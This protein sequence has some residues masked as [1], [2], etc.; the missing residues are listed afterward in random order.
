MGNSALLTIVQNGNEFIKV[1]WRY[2]RQFFDAKDIYIFDYQS[3]DNSLSGVNC[4]I[5]SV[6][7]AAIEDVPVGNKLIN[8]LKTKLLDTY[9][10]VMYADYD[11]IVYHPKGLDYVLTL[12]WDYYTTQGYEVVHKVEKEL[13]INWNEPLLKQRNYWYRCPMYDKSLITAIDVKWA[14]GNHSII[15]EREIVKGNTS[16]TENFIL[17]PKYLDNLLLIHLHKI[18]FEHCV[19]LKEQNLGRKDKA[20]IGG[21]HNQL[22]RDDVK[23]WFQTFDCKLTPM[24]GVLKL[25]V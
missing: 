22:N 25:I 15:Q 1:W 23:K 21:F 16:R 13:P 19:K 7:Q 6:E 4:N 3:S 10:Y 18:D 5:I 12:G 14:H 8:D 9:N 11:E 17:K 24:P 2:Y 20:T